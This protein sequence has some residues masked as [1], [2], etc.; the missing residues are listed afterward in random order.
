MPTPTYTP[1]ATVTLGSAAASVTFG[2]IPATYR[3]LIIV[4][5]TLNSS[6]SENMKMR[7]NSD[8]GASYTSIGLRGNGSTASSGSFANSS[9]AYA[10]NVAFADASNRHNHIIQFLDYSAT[11]KHKHFLSRANNSSRGVDLIAGR[12]ANTSAITTIMFFYEVGNINSGSR[13]D[14]YGIVS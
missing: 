6:G 14:L 13:F 2:S 9:F 1:L 3:D 11:D 5:D 12:W 10:D 7:F 8:S 4:T